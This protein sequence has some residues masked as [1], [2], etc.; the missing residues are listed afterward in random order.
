MSDFPG[1]SCVIFLSSL[2]RVPGHLSAYLANTLLGLIGPLKMGEKPW[3]FVV[4]RFH[5]E[6]VSVGWGG[7]GEKGSEA[8][9]KGL[10]R[11]ISQADLK[12]GAG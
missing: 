12:I 8:W 11:M 5:R 10:V 4:I 1:L 3:T 2:L 9:C 6:T 7:Y